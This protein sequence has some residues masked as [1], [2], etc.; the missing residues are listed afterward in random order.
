[1]TGELINPLK[2]KATLD[3]GPRGKL[4]G[5]YGGKADFKAHL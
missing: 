4:I 2:W 3:L 1:M 5:L